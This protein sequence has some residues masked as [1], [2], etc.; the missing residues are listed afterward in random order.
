M[1]LYRS[2][3]D[4]PLPSILYLFDPLPHAPHTHLRCSVG[5]STHHLLQLLWRFG[6]PFHLWNALGIALTLRLFD[7][8]VIGKHDLTL[9]VFR[10]LAVQD[11]RTRAGLA[12]QDVTCCSCGNNNVH[13][14][15][16]PCVYACPCV[17]VCTC[18]CPVQDVCP[19]VHVYM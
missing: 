9:V 19:T 7:G 11:V 12:Y 18:A 3:S 15:T 14:R 16:C 2:L 5:H 10:T 1:I 13:M 6:C 8:V 17:C 4:D